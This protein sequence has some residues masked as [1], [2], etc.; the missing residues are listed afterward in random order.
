MAAK[1]ISVFLENK[2]GRLAEVTKVL[3]EGGINLR[4]MTIA[5]TADFGILR[6]VADDTNKASQILND[7]GFTSKTT[8][9]LAMEVPDT[10]GGLAQ[11][12][13]VFSQNGVNIEYLY[14]S[15]EHTRDKAIIIFKVEDTVLGS[16]VLSEN[17][18][19]QL[20]EW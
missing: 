18:I 5:D 2:S 1:Q 13:A 10:P 8:D 20:T 11:L 19:A 4:A 6:L 3:G 12:L 15:L 9:V 16:K 14:A 17:S 7:G